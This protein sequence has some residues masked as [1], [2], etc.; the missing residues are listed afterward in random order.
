[1]ARWRIFPIKWWRKEFKGGYVL[2]SLSEFLCIGCV[3]VSTQLKLVLLRTRQKTSLA[4]VNG[5]RNSSVRFWTPT[6]PD[7]FTQEVL[8]QRKQKLM[9]MTAGK[10][11]LKT[12]VRLYI[13]MKLIQNDYYT[14]QTRKRCTVGY[15]TMRDVHW[16]VRNW[17]HSKSP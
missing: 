16:F 3:N 13:R 1:M 2:T 11:S 14:F 10:N 4:L 15:S 9:G 6:Y 7:N 8:A 17:L 5:V 12:I